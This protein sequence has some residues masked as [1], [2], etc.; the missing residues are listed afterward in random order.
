[1]SEG[2]ESP[3]IRIYEVDG[4]TTTDTANL[5][6]CYFEASQNS[7]DVYLFFGDGGNHIPTIPEFLIVGTPGFQF[8]RAGILWTVSE[9]VIDTSDP[10]NEK[11]NG[12]WSNPRNPSKG[13]DD[14]HFQAQSGPGPA[15]EVASSASA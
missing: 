13:D 7:P 15:E 14:G 3:K 12:H 5:M 4:G 8:I 9:F 6:G 1:M 11:A 10:S 2:P